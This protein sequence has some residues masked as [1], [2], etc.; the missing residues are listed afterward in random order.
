MRIESWAGATAVLLAL[1][2]GS[3]VA[4]PQQC[5]PSP[6]PPNVEL[7]Q[8]LARVLTRIYE[9]SPAFRLQCGRI[10]AADNLLVTVRIDT[11]I[12]RRCRAFTRIFRQGS[13]I[14]ANVHLPPTS[15]L[16]ELVGHEFE[17][18]LEQIEGLDLRKL[19]RVKGSGVHEVEGQ[20][21]ETDRAQA[22]GR[23]VA[24]EVMSSM[25]SPAA[26]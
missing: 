4:G 26:D 25:R 16:T 5:R 2:G 6:L 20:A 11:S 22:V 24:A 7:A 17:H 10:A 19:S 18:V 14:R 8:D 12:P 21:F 15:A 3:T 1:F 23:A 9:R 13:Y